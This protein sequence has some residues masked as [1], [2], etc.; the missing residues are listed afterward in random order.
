M[1]LSVINQKQKRAKF[2]DEFLATEPLPTS[3]KVE[4]TKLLSDFKA[5]LAR[6]NEL[7]QV[8]PTEELAIADMERQLEELN[9]LGRLRSSYD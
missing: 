8:G 2:W 4:T 7:G 9:E 6:C 1:D 5:I 3:L